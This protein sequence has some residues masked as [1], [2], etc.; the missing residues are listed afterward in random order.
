M[1]YHNI[2]Q[3]FTYSCY[4]IWYF[5]RQTAVLVP[6]SFNPW[7]VKKIIWFQS[8]TVND[9][10]NL[11]KKLI[12]IFLISNKFSTTC[13]FIK[14]VLLQLVKWESFKCNC[15]VRYEYLF[16]ILYVGGDYVLFIGWLLWSFDHYFCSPDSLI[17]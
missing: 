16:Y 2:S 4:Y 17:V 12:Y 1:I 6:E 14:Y 10:Y 3:T 11:H 7:F 9:E 5:G 13:E 15:H 8:A